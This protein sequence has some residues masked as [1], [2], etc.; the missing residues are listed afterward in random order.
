MNYSTK[1]LSGSTR[2]K[3]KED[4]LSLTSKYANETPYFP[5]CIAPNTLLSQQ[6]NG[7]HPH[8]ST[9]SRELVNS[10]N[11]MLMRIPLRSPLSWIY[12][13]AIFNDIPLERGGAYFVIAYMMYSQIQNS[14]C[15]HLSIKPCSP[16]HQMVVMV[17]CRHL[18]FLATNLLENVTSQ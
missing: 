16:V 8:K 3:R 9:I 5:P 18:A 14:H 4:D 13:D 11:D 2:N 12:Y 7:T 15:P 17:I 10:H 1:S 6:Q